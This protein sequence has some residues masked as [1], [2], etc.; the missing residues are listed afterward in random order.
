[1]SRACGMSRIPRDIISP[2]VRQIDFLPYR[3]SRL[4]VL[5]STR[6]ETRLVPLSS[7]FAIT[8]LVLH[9]S[10]SSRCKQA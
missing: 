4:Y 10:I 3:A 6:Q 8:R 1:V 2:L 7:F 5:V 9:V